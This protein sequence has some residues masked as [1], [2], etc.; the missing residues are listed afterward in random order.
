[1]KKCFLFIVVF[2]AVLLGFNPESMAHIDIS[3]P[4]AN[5]MISSDD[6][7]IIIDV[8]D[9]SEYCGELG[10]INGAYNY[11]WNLD[12]LQESYED[13]SIDDKIIIICH[14]GS[15]S[16]LAANFLDSKGYLYVYDILG[17]TNTWKNTYG[18]KTVGCVDSDVDGFNDDLDNCPD[19][20]NPLQTDS[21]NDQ[22]GN[23][24]D[25]DCPDL[26]ELNP[27]NIVDLAVIASNWQRSGT[28]FAGDLNSD[29]L[30]DI[31]DLMVFANYWLSDCYE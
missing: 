6:D 7:L 4:D 2:C 21:D 26:D 10:H 29:G 31:V 23:A 15:R 12:V 17:G 3:I 8:R 19:A 1:M 16:N 18:Y 14:S 24:C 22:I 30:V 5:E 27:V 25:N 28:G 11:S 9:H 20:H 13:F